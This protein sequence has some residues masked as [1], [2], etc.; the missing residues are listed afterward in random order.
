MSAQETLLGLPRGY[1]DLDSVMGNPM[2][3]TYHFRMV[4][5]TH[6]V[7]LGLFM[8]LGLPHYVLLNLE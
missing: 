3:Q 6:C 2:P 8:A 7:I 4:Y 1:K 5:T